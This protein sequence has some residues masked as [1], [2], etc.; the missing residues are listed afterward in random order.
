MANFTNQTIDFEALPQFETITFRP[1]HK[2]YLNV[3]Y[4]SNTV[5]SIVLALG[6]L[7]LLL[8]KEASRAYFFPLFIALVLVIVALFWLSTIAF[9]KKGFAIRERDI[10]FRKGLLA[11]TTTIIPFNRIQHVALHEGVLSR[12][13][14]LSELQV[15]TA[16]GSSSDLHIVGLPKAQAEQIKTYLLGIIENEDPKVI[17]DQPPF[18][19]ESVSDTVF[20][21]PISE[22]NE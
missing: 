19:L 5:F 17:D 20:T 14:A 11:T 15:Y 16:G 12:I 18:A 10:L 13:Y 22:S 9:N 6:V 4:I 3:L 8:F 21:H 2:D 7:V 1:L